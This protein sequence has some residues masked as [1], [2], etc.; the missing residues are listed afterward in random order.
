MKKWKKVVTAAAAVLA[1]VASTAALAGCSGGAKVS[2]VY[3]ANPGSEGVVQYMTS[4][5][6]MILSCNESLEVYDDNT[7]CL[8]AISTVISGLAPDDEG[9]VSP[10]CR[11][12]T[13]VEYYG[14]YTSEEDSGMMV[15]TLST[16][17]R[18]TSLNSD[19]LM[20]GGYPIGYIDTDNFE[21]SEE[22]DAWFSG[23]GGG[24]EGATCT[25]EALLEKVA[26]DETVV[27]VSESGTFDFI[28]VSYADVFMGAAFGR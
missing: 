11:G 26:F 22:L 16:P 7:Y 20:T 10:I 24:G 13:T 3:V 15:Y 27:V 21:G 8:T 25:A 23:F 6:T 4:P 9:N 2:D 19:N 28:K 5:L 12:T 14:T 18:F 1:V 17:T